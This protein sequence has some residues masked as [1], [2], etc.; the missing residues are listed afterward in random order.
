MEFTATID[1]A[2]VLDAFQ[3]LG[4]TIAERTRAA[5][6]QAASQIAAEQRRRVRRRTGA[7]ALGIQVIDDYTKTG[8]V[9]LTTDMR[10]RPTKRGGRYYKE[11]HV[12]TYLEYSTKF[13]RAHPFFYDAAKLQQPAFMR[14]IEVAVQD[15]INVTG[16]GS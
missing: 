1:T 11:L 13:M 10:D 9:V 15:G 7:T 14:A 12:G 16:L 6:K 4:P 3:R 5:A 8:Y 2:P